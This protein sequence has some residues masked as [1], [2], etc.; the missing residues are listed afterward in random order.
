M[1]R[2]PP[3][4]T[5]FPYT[6]LFR[7]EDRGPNLLEEV[8]WRELAIQVGVH[9]GVSH[10]LPVVASQVAALVRRRGEPVEVADAAHAD[11]PQRG[12]LLKDV[13]HGAPAVAHAE[14]SEPL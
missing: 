3:R 6:T 4:S 14:G 11:R 10:L 13:R 2:R 5:L 1:I 7:S 8:D 9:R 12:R